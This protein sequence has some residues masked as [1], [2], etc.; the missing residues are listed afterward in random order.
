[1]FRKPIA[2]LAGALFLVGLV[3][4]PAGAK[5]GD[6]VVK[7]R[8]TLGAKSKLKLAPRASDGRTKIEFEVD[9]NRNGQ[10][11]N[12]RITDKGAIVFAGAKATAAPSGSFT[13]RTRVPGASG[14]RVSA[15]ATDRVSRQTCS[16]N[17]SV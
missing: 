17:A 11:W 13:V 5:D 3:A 15:T 4:A 7:S 6:V 12:V 16:I 10:I 1:M 8:C 2:A 9:S 14:H